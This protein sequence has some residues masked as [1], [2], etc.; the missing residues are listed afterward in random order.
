MLL[1]GPERSSGFYNGCALVSR[2]RIMPRERRAV[3][4]VAPGGW[5]VAARKERCEHLP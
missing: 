1:Y 5:T 4:V 3:I 2:G